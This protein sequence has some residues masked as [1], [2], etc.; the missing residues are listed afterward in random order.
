MIQGVIFDM[1][2]LMFDTERMWAS[3]WRPALAPLGLPY[4]EGLDEDVRGTAGDTMRA[5]LRKHYGPGCDTEAIIESLHAV[6]EKAFAAPVPKKPGLDELLAYLKGKGVPMAVA[7]SS[8][9]N[10]VRRHLKNGGI[11]PYF[12][13]VLAGGAVQRSKPAPDIF[14]LAAEKLGVRPADCLVL[15]DSYNGVRAGHAGGFVTIMVPDLLP[16]DEEMRRLYTTECVSLHAVRRLLDETGLCPVRAPRAAVKAVFFDID[17]TLVSFKTHAVPPSTMRA[18][19]ALHEKGVKLFIASGRPPVWLDI[20]RDQLE[21]FPFDG[22]VLMNG[23]YCTDAAGTP[24]HSQPLPAGAFPTLL[25]WLEAN[26]DVVCSFVEMDYAYENRHTEATLAAARQA[27]MYGPHAPV[28]D[29]VRALTHATYQ[30][31]P[32]IPPERDAEFL[33]HAPGCRAVR[34]ND[35]FADVIPADGGKPEGV[36]R[37]LE[38]FG[39]TAAECMA[40]GDG[41]NDI[42]MLRFAGIGV[43]MGNAAP[44]VKAAA[45]YVAG[46]IDADGLEKALAHFGLL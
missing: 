23:Q 45:D 31:N 41:G 26:P 16:A 43:A 20:L 9:E 28:E 12:D 27:G 15:E 38:R 34:W 1:D 8:R 39:L 21:N 30:M 18:L 11:E 35:I 36:K 4:S 25:P 42:D 22:Y 14:L 2:G 19:R 29:P 40:F 6:A 5:V 37:M 17:G 7:S 32:Y 44:A 13:V 46:D 33:A 3:F 10:V 24:F